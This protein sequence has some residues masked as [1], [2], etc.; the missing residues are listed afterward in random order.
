MPPTLVSISTV[1]NAAVQQQIWQVETRL[2]S[3][4]V[5]VR[6]RVRVCVRADAQ[7]SYFVDMRARASSF[8]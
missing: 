5:L 6:W 1:A 8:N 7:R 2:K 4:R 3:G